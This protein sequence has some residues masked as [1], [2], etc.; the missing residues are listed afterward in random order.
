MER[1]SGQFTVAQSARLAT[2]IPVQVLL[3]RHCQ[4]KR[5]A[6]L[7]RVFQILYIWYLNQCRNREVRSHQTVGE[8]QP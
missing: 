5:S 2:I 4:I 3:M 8:R 7:E 1:M 6:D